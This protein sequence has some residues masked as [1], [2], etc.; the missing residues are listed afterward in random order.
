VDL[1]EIGARYAVDARAEFAAEIRRLESSGY[2]RN[3]D[4]LRLARRGWRVADEIGA[5]F[6]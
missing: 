6:L 2:V 3:T 1:D 4:R 5:A